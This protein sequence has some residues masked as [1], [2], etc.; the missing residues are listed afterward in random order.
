MGIMGILSVAKA[1][2]K[3]P[4][5]TL[6]EPGYLKRLIDDSIPV[7]VKMADN[8]SVK[9]VIEY[10]DST[11]LRLTRKGAPNLF[12]YKDQIKYLYEEPA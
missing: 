1:G 2:T 12:I 5:Q 8:D 10:Y 3:A 11:F 6:E 9:G 4:D 7:C